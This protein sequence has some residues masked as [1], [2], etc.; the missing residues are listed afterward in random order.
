MGHTYEDLLEAYADGV[1][2][3]PDPEAVI[4]ANMAIR[5]IHPA[6]DEDNEGDEDE[7]R[8]RGRGR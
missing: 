2:E 5:E 4:I 1:A 6:K 7:S 8:G 3:K